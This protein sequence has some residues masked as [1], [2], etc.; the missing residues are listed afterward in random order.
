M[1]EGWPSKN[2]CV[3]PATVLMKP[4]SS[5]CAAAAVPGPMPVPQKVTI[6]PGATT[7]GW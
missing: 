1:G 5:S 6:S 3:A 2:T 7:P 4:A